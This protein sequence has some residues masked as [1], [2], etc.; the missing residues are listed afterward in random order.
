MDSTTADDRSVQR[1]QLDE[2]IASEALL[3]APELSADEVPKP[4]E[5]F[6]KRRRQPVAVAGVVENG[7]VRLL[8]P[9][10]HLPERSRVIVVAAG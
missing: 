8:D 6:L 10:V 2:A 1:R 7:L 9:S 3:P 5:A 4:M